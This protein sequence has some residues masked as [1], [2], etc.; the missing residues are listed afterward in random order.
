MQWIFR[1]LVFFLFF[2]F[3]FFF[4]LAFNANSFWCVQGWEAGSEYPLVHGEGGLAKAHWLFTHKSLRWW[5]SWPREAKEPEGSCQEGRGWRWRWRRRRVRSRVLNLEI[6]E[7]QRV[8]SV[9]PFFL[10]DFVNFFFLVI[11]HNYRNFCLI[12]PWPFFF[13]F[14]FFVIVIG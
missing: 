7:C 14:F 3:S 13:F 10:S 5:A 12:C 8:F 11:C 1:Y 4:E 9:F 6:R 2:F